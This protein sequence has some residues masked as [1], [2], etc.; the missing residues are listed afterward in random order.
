MATETNRSRRPTLAVVPRARA[1]TT[2]V[3]GLTLLGIVV[4]WLIENLV[5]NPDQFALVFL[6][7]LTN[8]SIYALVAIGYTLVYGILELINFAHGD[9][10]TWGAMVTSTVAVSWLAADT[11]NGAALF[12]SLL[13]AIV[14]A[15]CFCA[16]LNVTVERVA[17]RRL[18]NAPRLAP[19]IT[20]IGMS[21]VLSNLI[22]VFYGFDYVT[23]N[24]ILPRGA[25]FYIGSTPYTWD[26]FIV[27]LI[28][29]PVLFGLSV[30]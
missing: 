11:K 17:Y 21:F 9:V 10:F 22:A 13:V 26:K 29:F 23:S 15:A 1:L 3:V 28:T 27:L 25:I 14:A 6:N 16:V 18:R 24:P 7:G 8:G 5:R 2:K 19:L 4:V 20:A 12:G 30:V